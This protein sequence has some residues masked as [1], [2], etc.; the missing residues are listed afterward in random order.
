M[1]RTPLALLVLV[2][3]LAPL[4]MARAQPKSETK[5]PAAK[6]P[7][8]SVTEQAV[9]IHSSTG[10]LEVRYRATA[11]TL[12]VLDDAGKTKAQMFYI[13]YERLGEAGPDGVRHPD[14]ARPITFTFN[15]GP[16]SSSVWLHMGAMGPRRVVMGDEGEPPPPPGRTIPNEHSWLDLTDL[17]FIDPVSTGFSRAVEGEDPK[18][19]HGLDED[20]KSVGDF[21]RLYTTRNERWG[22]PKYLVGESYGTTRAAGLSGY[23]Q[24]TAGMYLTGIALVSPV[25]HFQTVRFDEGNDTPYW[26]YLPTYTATAWYHKK[27]PPDLQRDLKTALAESERYASGP[28]ML[29]L[30]KGDALAGQE[31]AQVASQLAR[32]TGLST[33]FIE[34][35]NLRVPIQNFTKEL[36]RDEGRTVGRLDSR[37]KGIDRTGN[38]SSPDYDPSMSAIWGPYTAGF[39][40]YVRG[41]LGYKTDTVYEIMTGR[42]SPWSYRNASNRYANVAETLRAAMSRNRDLRVLVMCGYYDLATP[43]FAAEHTFRTMQLD[44]E[45]RGNVSFVYYESGHMMYIRLPDLAKFKADGRRLYEPAPVPAMR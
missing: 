21:I 6:P 41:E 42:V 15:G 17:V 10:P 3:L 25:L 2:L 40:A 38:T 20:I 31:R 14:P 33:A 28:Y 39:N 26:L 9:T 19:F 24:E 12:P 36:L 37:F 35:A 7:E 5:E 16:G 8:A 23:L 32:F 22:S 11:G 34:R 13:A 27:L 29:A 44:P 1:K 30:V 18:Q 43:H 4:A 45:L